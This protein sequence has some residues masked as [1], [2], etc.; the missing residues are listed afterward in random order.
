MKKLV[1]EIGETAAECNVL[2][3]GKKLGLIQSV[4]VS[5]DVNHDNPTP[6]V[7]V[8]FFD[9]SV[10]EG[11]GFLMDTF[12]DSVQALSGIPYVKMFSQEPVKEHFVSSSMPE[13]PAD[14]AK[15]DTVNE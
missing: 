6:I 4:R 7:E 5:I 15:W 2:V 14:L 10:Y 13:D 3:D 11:V 9:L 1:I 12:K 8:I